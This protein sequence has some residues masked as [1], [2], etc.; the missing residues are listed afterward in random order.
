MASGRDWGNPGRLDDQLDEGS[1]ASGLRGPIGGCE[2]SGSMPV[3]P[4]AD[5]EAARRRRVGYPKDIGG[6]RVLTSSLGCL[7]TIGRMSASACLLPPE[8]TPQEEH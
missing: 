3:Q 5:R 4:D 8:E 7:L 2:S 1:L 6:V